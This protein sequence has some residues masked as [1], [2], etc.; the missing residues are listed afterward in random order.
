MVGQTRHAAAE[1]RTYSVRARSEAEPDVAVADGLT[2]LLDAVDAALEWLDDADPE[3]DGTNR[4]VILENRGDDVEEVWRYP[5]EPSQEGR[6]FVELYGFDPTRRGAI[7]RDFGAG[8][9]MLGLSERIASAEPPRELPPPDLPARTTP[10]AE[11]S[12]AEP[13]REDEPEPELDPAADNPQETLSRLAAGGRALVEFAQESWDDLLS[14]VCLIVSA[15]FLWL[16]IGL[17]DLRFLAP[18][19]VLLPALHRRGRMLRKAAAANRIEDL[20]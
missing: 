11:E 9:R 7:V 8:G 19:L 4:L 12:E 15:V 14:R 3:R 17:I 6:V 20:L 2:E 18:L 13:R 5:S 16:A 1:R 10:A